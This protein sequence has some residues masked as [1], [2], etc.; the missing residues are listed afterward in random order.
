MDIFRTAPLDRGGNAIVTIQ[1]HRDLVARPAVTPAVTHG[2]S[3]ISHL[4]GAH[5]PHGQLGH[6][7]YRVFPWQA[8]YWSAGVH[9]CA[10]DC[11]D[12]GCAE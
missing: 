1:Q 3:A 5:V 8:E 4:R 9:T 10:A 2:T 12:G 6:R 11:P 7:C